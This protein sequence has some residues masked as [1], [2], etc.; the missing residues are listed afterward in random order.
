MGKDQ[1]TLIL[2]STSPRRREL[3][4]RFE[5][6]FEL[7]SV[8]VDE[9]AL[10]A[11][12]PQELV[13]RLGRAK[14]QEGLHR[15]PRLGAMV[16]AADTV[17]SIDGQILGKPEDPADAIRMLK[18]LRGRAHIVYSGLV[19]ATRER[20]VA[21]LAETTVWMRDY[22]D[23]EIDSYVA[24]G[25]PLDKAAAYAIQHPAFH[26]VARI[27]GCYSNVMGLPLCRLYLALMEFGVQIEHPERVL[28]NPPEEDCPE[29]R[30][31]KSEISSPKSDH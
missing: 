22:A 7:A 31:I 4:T 29:A 3:I 27:D 21:E 20:Q 16:I 19:V 30:R 8:N 13:Q 25:D 23:A 12:S 9:S 18:Q 17:V 5:L 1:S 14:A 24:T 11:E 28:A 2:A 6:P 15:S 26:P 10:P